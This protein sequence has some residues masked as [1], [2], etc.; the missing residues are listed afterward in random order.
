MI[1]IVAFQAGIGGIVI[2]MAILAGCL[3]M[4]GTISIASAGVIEAGIPIAGIVAL[5]AVS[6]KLP[7]VDG[8]FSVAGNTRAGSTFIHAVGMALRAG[9]VCMRTGQFEGRQIMIESG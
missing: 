7:L 8:W 4:S 6:S 5:S 2:R 3:S 1:A 9:G